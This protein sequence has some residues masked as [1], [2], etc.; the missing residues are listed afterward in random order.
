M[1]DMQAQEIANMMEIYFLEEASISKAHSSWFAMQSW[2]EIYAFYQKIRWTVLRLGYGR[3]DARISELKR[4]VDAG[5]ISKD[6][7]RKIANVSLPD[8]TGVFRYFWTEKKEQPLV[9]VCVAVYNAG[10]FLQETLE[11]VLNQTYTNIEFLVVDDCS[12]DNSRDVITSWQKKD[13]RVKPVFMESNS[14]VCA[15]V[16]AGLRER[17]ER[18]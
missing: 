13:N 9:S 1:P 18:M 6:A 11:S 17:R 8:T 4:M 16:N 10:G 5:E 2:S 12:T 7:I 3:A 14:N 15:A